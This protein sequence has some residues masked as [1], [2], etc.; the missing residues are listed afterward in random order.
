MLVQIS[1]F[2]IET[3]VGIG[4]EN[5]IIDRSLSPTIETAMLKKIP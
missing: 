5:G 3:S 2:I 4:A 1:I